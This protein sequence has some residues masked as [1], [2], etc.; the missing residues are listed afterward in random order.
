MALY[1]K[2]PI[3]AFQ[4]AGDMDIDGYPEW[5]QKAVK[6]GVVLFGVKGDGKCDLIIS[7]YDEV[8]MA[9]SGD[10]I[11]REGGAAIYPCKPNVFAAIYE[12]A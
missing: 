5:F 10:F 2:K 11:V 8:R 4:W 6:D 1:R 9:S 3:E 12:P 7:G